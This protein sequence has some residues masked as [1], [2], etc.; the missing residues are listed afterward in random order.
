MAENLSTS[1]SEIHSSKKRTSPNVQLDAP[2]GL[3]FERIKIS[4]QTS[5]VDTLT[6]QQFEISPGTYVISIG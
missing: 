1:T 3:H 2:Q 6:E 5:T 4:K